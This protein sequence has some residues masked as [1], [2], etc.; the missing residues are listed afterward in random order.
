MSS[1][2]GLPFLRRHADLSL[3]LLRVLTGSF[4]VYGTQDNV[5]SA[6]RMEEFVAFLDHHGFIWPELMAPLSVYAQFV[7]GGLLVLGLLTRWAA[8]VMVFNFIV[9]VVMVHW[10]Q[11][12]RGW[13]PAIVLVF[14]CL[15]FACRGGGRYSLDSLVLEKRQHAVSLG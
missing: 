7:C 11:D 10:S 9:A 14:I 1:A 8:L 6:E 15:D 4:L 12:F 13:W 3:L 2:L 5:F